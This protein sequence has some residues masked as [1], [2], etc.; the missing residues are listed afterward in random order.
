MYKSKIIVLF[1]T[2]N[3]L[4]SVFYS[5]EDEPDE[6]KQQFAVLRGGEAVTVWA[7][8]YRSGSVEIF[9]AEKTGAP[10]TTLMLNDEQLIA[11]DE[12]EANFGDYLSN[13]PSVECSYDADFTYRVILTTIPSDTTGTCGTTNPIIPTSLSTGLNILNGFIDNSF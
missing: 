3:A 5:C 12:M 11:M 7:N 13:Y 9:I 4:C 1:L 6:L 8:V 10:D 2:I